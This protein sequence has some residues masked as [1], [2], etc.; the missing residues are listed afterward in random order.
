MYKNPEVSSSHVTTS[1]Q[2][3]RIY[4]EYQAIPSQFTYKNPEIHLRRL[5]PGSS[6]L[7]RLDTVRCFIQNDSNR[8]DH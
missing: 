3:K 2:L 4:W 5:A 1:N 7:I 6:F 8:I